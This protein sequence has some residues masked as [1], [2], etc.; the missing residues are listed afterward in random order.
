[1]LSKVAVI[2]TKPIAGSLHLPSLWAVRVMSLVVALSALS[3]ICAA[4]ARTP[5]SRDGNAMLYEMVLSRPGARARPAP[6][7]GD[8]K[9]LT[10]LSVLYVYDRKPQGSRDWIE[11]G[12]DA[13]GAVS[14]WVD[15]LEVVPWKQTLVLSLSTAATRDPLMFFS[16]KEEL[17]QIVELPEAKRIETVSSIRAKVKKK[18]T[19]DIPVIAVAAPQPPDRKENINIITIR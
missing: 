7:A 8:G 2:T 13:Q 4:Q 9:P 15:A 19:K 18:R 16:G 5:I 3:G 17:R 1:M 10:P 11:V 12:T 6:S 14:G